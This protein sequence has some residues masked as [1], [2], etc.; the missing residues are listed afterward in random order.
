MSSL[1]FSARYC[2]NF[3]ANLP[4]IGLTAVSGNIIM[5]QCPVTKL[6]SKQ[7]RGSVFLK[8]RIQ[9]QIWIQNLSESGSGSRVLMTKNGKKIQ[10]KIFLYLLLIK[11]CNL[12]IP[13]GLHKG[14]ASYRRSLQPSKEN[15]QHFRKISLLTDSYFSGSFF[16]P[17]SRSRD[18]I[19]SG[20]S[21][22]PDT[23]PD[24]QHWFKLQVQRN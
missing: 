21:P 19:E 8:I 6:C 9:I 4:S 22:D 18:P 14:R 20:S 12:L 5:F 15:S 3:I 1:N 7:C 11:I 2:Q 17:G 23:D 13:R 10:L 16:P 24:P